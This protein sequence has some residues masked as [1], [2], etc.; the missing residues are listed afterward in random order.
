[1]LGITENRSC[2]AS[3]APSTCGSTAAC[4]AHP[5]GSCARMNVFFRGNVKWKGE[6]G[7]SCQL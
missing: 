3:S 2:G 6:A 7:W 1:M 5:S 4:A